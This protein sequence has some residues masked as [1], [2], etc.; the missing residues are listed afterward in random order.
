MRHR[1]TRWREAWSIADPCTCNS[2]CAY[3]GPGIAWARW[4]PKRHRPWLL[5]ES[6]YRGAGEA[7]ESR[8]VAGLFA[9][10]EPERKNLER[11]PMYRFPNT[12]AG[13]EGPTQKDASYG[14]FTVPFPTGVTTTVTVTVTGTPRPPHQRA[15]SWPVNALFLAGIRLAN[16][17]PYRPDPLERTGST[18]ASSNLQS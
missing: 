4:G 14:W 5:G 16:H 17:R 11:A 13:I 2:S 15:A 1:I 9:T 8:H 6:V 12:A 3:G 18:A 7:R 10:P